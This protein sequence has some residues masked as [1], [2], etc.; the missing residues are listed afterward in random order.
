MPLR[1]LR[2]RAMPIEFGIV[3]PAKA[4]VEGAKTLQTL[5]LHPI[6][7]CCGVFAA[8]WL[9][10][11]SGRAM[12]SPQRV[13]GVHGGAVDAAIFALLGLLIAFTF[14][15]AATRFE[16]RRDLIVQEANAIGTAFLRVDLAPPATQP[17]LRDAFRDYMQ[18]RVQAYAVVADPHAFQA[19]LGKSAA[20]QQRIWQLAIDAGRRA[21]AAP[22]TNML[23]LPAINDMI[24][25]TTIRTM[26]AQKHS[27]VAIYMML[28]VLTLVGAVLAGFS[29]GAGS[30]RSWLHM[31]SFAVTMTLTIYVIIDMEYPRLGLIK[32]DR[33]EQA[34]IRLSQ[35]R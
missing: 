6:I 30:R 18:S 13:Q 17:A 10:L 21:D 3:A 20:L 7:S 27:P 19:A 29:M 11:E 34:T 4:P 26:A 23:L 16:Q 5:L 9:A 15:G 22:A 8:L 31:L 1:E 24:D 33:F 35:P 25:I 12:A 14:S 28:F 2:I 32:V